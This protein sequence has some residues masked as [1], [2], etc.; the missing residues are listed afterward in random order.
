MSVD[1]SRG[2]AASGDTLSAS[3]L[4]FARRFNTASAPAPKFARRTST[5]RN[6][7]GSVVFERH[8][9]EVPESWSQLATDILASKYFR[10]SGLFGQVDNSETSAEQVVNRI[11]RTISVYGAAH[12]YFRDPESARAF[13]AELSYLLLHQYGAFNSPVW[14]NVGLFHEYG[15][16]GSGGHYRYDEATGEVMRMTNA[17]EHPQA[18]ACFIT[19]VG[20]SIDSIA[21]GIKTEMRLFKY[22]SGVGW[23]ASTLRSKYEKLSGGG[24][25]SGLLSFLR[26]YDRAAGSTK[27][28]GDSRRAAKMVCLDVD[29]PE[30]LDFITWKAREEKK[31]QALIA[32]G[33]PADFNGESYETVSGQNSNNSIRITDAFMRAVEADGPWETRFRTTGAVHATLRARTIWR[34]IAESAWA[35]ADPG[36]QYDTTINDWHTCKNTGRIRASNPCCFTGE[37][38]VDTSEGRLSFAQLEAMSSRGEALPLAYSFD[39]HAGLPVLRS[40]RKA[41]VAGETAS[42]VDVRTRRGV[43]VRCTPEHRFLLRNGEYVEAQALRPG[44]RLRKIPRALNAARGE[45]RTLNHR[46][47]PAAPRGTVW[48]NRFVWE[49]A[50]GPIPSGFHVHHRNEDPT[51][52]RLSNLELREGSDHIQEHTAGE[53]NPRFLDVDARVL[54]EAWEAIEARVEQDRIAAERVYARMAALR[55]AGHSY[56]RVAAILDEEGLRPLRAETWGAASVHAACRQGYVGRA[57]TAVTVARWNAYVAEMGLQG[58]LPLANTARGIQ[59]MS[60]D[61]FGAWIEEH[62]EDVNDAVESVTPVALDAAVKVYDIEVDGT[63][64]FGV[65]APGMTA[66]HTLVVSNSEYMFLDDSACNLASLNLTKFLRPAPLGVAEEFDVEA[67]RHAVRVFFTAQEILVGMSSYPT[68]AIAQNSY[69]YRPLG[70]GYANLGTLLM[71]LGLPYDSEAGRAHASCITALMH[72]HAGTVSAELAAAVGPFAGYEANKTPMRDVMLKHRDA[73]WRIPAGLVPE[74]LRAAVYQDARD[75]VDHGDAHGYRNAQFTVLAP[76]G[77]IGLLMDCDTTGVEPDFALVKFK[78]LAG[79]GSLRIVNASVAPALRT[80]GYGPAAVAAIL[81]YV[82]GTGT[83]AGDPLVAPAALVARGLTP[84][85]VDLVEARLSGAFSL[86]MALAQSLRPEGYARLGIAEAEYK[87]PTFSLLRRLGFA[88]ADVDLATKRVLGHHTV[89]GA[90][91]LAAEHYAVFDCASRCGDGTRFLAPR[92]HLE[93]MAATQ[94]FLSGAISKTV[95]LPNEATVDEIAETYFLGWKLGLKAVA[96]Y[97]DGCKASQPLSSST[98][99]E[100]PAARAAAIDVETLPESEARVLLERLQAR[101]EQAVQPAEQALVQAQLQIEALHRQLAD[102]KPAA[103]AVR[104]R[105]PKRRHGITQEA[106]VGGTKLFLRTGEYPDGTVGELFVDMHKEG[107]AFRSIVNCFAIAVSMGLQYGVPLEAYVEQFTFT[108]FEPAGLVEGDDCIRT[109]GSILDY[110]FRHLGVH[111]L[112]RDDLAHVK[113]TALLVDPTGPATTRAPSGPAT[114]GTVIETPAG[115]AAG[116]AASAAAFAAPPVPPKKGDAP[117]CDQ[118]GCLTVRNGTCFRCWNCGSSMG[119]S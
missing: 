38:L 72:C 88:K 62:R 7:D 28:G 58:V 98:K 3:G 54:V 16:E 91:H 43:V 64:N 56:A 52:D 101:F 108:R 116:I 104:R 61:A 20:D 113:P 47:T 100:A 75:L 35:C 26:V 37:M 53:N 90:P 21:D 89:E 9:V 97:R 55:K 19:S 95:N 76:T 6:P 31:A 41:W 40:I 86:D 12:G 115:V 77:T 27:S 79:G 107:A 73:A 5:I 4:T 119:C 93:M 74:A 22:G 85:E 45:R 111:Y 59:G 112:Q 94:P 8:D 30:I 17:Y 83:L 96:L 24:T 71:R 39:R 105:L 70:L 102:Q 46:A 60:W 69:D 48:Q 80:L 92:A 65:T 87:A 36:V 18:S 109:S 51:D 10:K 103:E 33:Y 114:S 42:L 29:H 2:P 118:C 57:E 110:I 23:N 1:V 15:I 106:R 25:S 68:A 66:L 34:S 82:N 32:A 78:K 11:A 81:T 84:T 49:Q 50:K 99:T 67:F 14:F 13:N 117:F 44:Q 63:H